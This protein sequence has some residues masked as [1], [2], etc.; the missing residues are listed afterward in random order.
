VEQTLVQYAR[1]IPE[2][3]RIENEVQISIARGDPTSAW[4]KSMRLLQ[5]SRFDQNKY[6]LIARLV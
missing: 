2:M 1:I 5:L 4:D 6:R 3:T